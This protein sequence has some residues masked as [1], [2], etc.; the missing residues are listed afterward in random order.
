MNKYVISLGIVLL[1]GTNAL[2]VDCSTVSIERDDLDMY[3]LINGSTAQSILNQAEQ[4]FSTVDHTASIPMTVADK[5]ADPER[6]SPDSRP[7]DS[8]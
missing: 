2:A 7:D 8:E 5:F 1:S 4:G 3:S 6:G